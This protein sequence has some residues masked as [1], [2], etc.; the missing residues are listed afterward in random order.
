M[1][2]SVI[3]LER[4]GVDDPVGA[5]SVH[6][7][8]GVWGVVAVALFSDDASLGPQL[9]GAAAIIAWAF[10]L[11]FIVFKAIDLT[12][13]LRVSREEEAT[14]LD[15]SEHGNYAYPEFVFQHEV[16]DLVEAANGDE[17][18]KREPAAG[19]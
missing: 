2:G 13:G 11:S 15:I 1:V 7:T 17:D 16:V 5:I 10:A 9:V 14:G 18:R 3:F 19:A 4:V 6:G 8:V 12:A